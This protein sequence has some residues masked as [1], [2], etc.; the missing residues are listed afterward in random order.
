MAN[1]YYTVE[2]HGKMTKAELAKA[3]ATDANAFDM[4]S[5][6]GFDVDYPMEI[7]E[8]G[9]LD[10]TGESFYVEEEFFITDGKCTLEVANMLLECVK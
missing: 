10:N 2:Y 7:N 6:G 9:H 1:N 4:G 5:L 3:I 8:D